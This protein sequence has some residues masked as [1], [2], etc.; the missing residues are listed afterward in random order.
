M[1]LYV[2]RCSWSRLSAGK[3]QNLETHVYIYTLYT[4]TYS[5]TYPKHNHTGM[6]SNICV[7]RHKGCEYPTT[8][9][10]CASPRLV[11]GCPQQ[12][13]TELRPHRH[14]SHGTAAA[15]AAPANWVTAAKSR[16]RVGAQGRLAAAP[17]MSWMA[18]SHAWGE[19]APVPPA[20]PAARSRDTLLLHCLPFN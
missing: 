7:H 14:G 19:H 17:G 12:R 4:H 2:L 9:D 13:G 5:C 18:T 1:C 15:T 11:S 8:S 6:H 20:G 10:A 3:T 16:G